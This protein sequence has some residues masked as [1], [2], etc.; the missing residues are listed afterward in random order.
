MH[1][2]VVCLLDCA[3]DLQAEERECVVHEGVPEAVCGEEVFV[4]R[5][6]CF[7]EL[8][9]CY[10]RGGRNSQ[11]SASGPFTVNSSDVRA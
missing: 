6:Y 1:L 10:L 4:V 7:E 5:V 9:G 3:C 8:C 2:L 11:E